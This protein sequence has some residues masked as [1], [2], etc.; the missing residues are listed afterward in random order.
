MTSRPMTGSW[1]TNAGRRC[2]S[3]PIG[4]TPTRKG[5]H[6]DRGRS[7]APEGA[8]VGVGR[9][10][11][12]AVEVAAKGGR[13]A[14]A[15]R[16]RDDVHAVVGGLQKLLSPPDPLGQQPLQR[17]GAGRR[18]E[19]PAEVACA[20]VGPAGQILHGQ[21]PVEPPGRPGEHVAQRLA[22]RLGNRRV[23]EL[24][25][26]AGPVRRYDQPPGDRVGDLR[27]VIAPDQ[28]QAQIQ[29]PGRT[30]RPVRR[31][32][33]GVPGRRTPAGEVVLPRADGRP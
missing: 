2:C 10:A 20:Q 7:S 31:G 25:L 12:G 19:V 24:S 16:L 3:G 32:P 8:A 22:V 6:P 28:V 30:A 23:D 13:G 29:P 11:E 26:P 27:A 5:D 1:P 33:A 14:H 9:Y 15:G 17:R 21:R 18:L 4:S